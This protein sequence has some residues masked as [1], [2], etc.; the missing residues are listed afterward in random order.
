MARWARATAFQCGGLEEKMGI[1]G[2]ATC[3]MNYEGATGYLVG[4]ASQ[5]HAHHVR[6]DERGAPRRRHARPRAGGSRVPERGDF[7]RER[8]QGRSIT[9]AKAPDKPADPI[10]VHPD[11]RRM[12]MDMKAFTEGG[13]AFVYWT[14]LQ[15]DLRTDL[16]GCA[17]A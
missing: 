14:A 10:I 2:N 1:H 6:D 12:L 5:G 7:A 9:G 11:V 8:V 16:A 4:E 13:R 17:C 15:G 3:V